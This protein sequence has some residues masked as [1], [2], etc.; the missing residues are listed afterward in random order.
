MARRRKKRRN[1][2]KI[3]MRIVAVVVLAL[4]VVVNANSMNLRAKSGTYQE[5]TDKLNAQIDE[6][7]QRTKEIED[8]KKYVNT[9][10]YIEEVAKDKLGLV[11][12]DEIIFKPEDKRHIL[13]ELRAKVGIIG[14][15]HSTCDICNAQRRRYQQVFGFFHAFLG[16]IF[17]EI[18]SGIFFK[19]AA[20]IIFTDVHKAGKI[21]Q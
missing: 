21:I 18:T 14:I 5:R 8:L 9:K 19:Q 4:V 3:G 15:A 6:E 12:D 10:K 16:D 20:C 1:Q 17:M 13:L 11:Y 7:K 2:N